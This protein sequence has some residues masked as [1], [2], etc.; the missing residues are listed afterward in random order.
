MVPR[1]PTVCLSDTAVYLTSYAPRIYRIVT[2]SDD[3][4]VKVVA[5]ETGQV[6]YDTAFH[7]DWVHTVVFTSEFFISGSDDRQDTLPKFFPCA[8]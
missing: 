3:R 1:R 4:K 5:V 2:G 6:I 7:G 8:E